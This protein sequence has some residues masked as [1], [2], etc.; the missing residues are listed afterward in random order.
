M[1]ATA[2]VSA[3]V[4][5]VFVG[6]CS[7]G[8]VRY[9]G[10]SPLGDPGAVEMRYSS[11]E[12]GFLD[13]GGSRLQAGLNFYTITS[14]AGAGTTFGTFCVE[15]SQ[16][17]GQGPA[18]YNLV[19]LPETPLPGAPMTQAQADEISA[20]LASARSLGWIG[21]RL[22]ADA[23][24][25]N[26]LGRI[27]AIQAA[28]WATLGGDVDVDSAQTSSSIRDA[29]TELMSSFDG[30]LRYAGL[31]GLVNDRR[32]DVLYVVPLPTA[33]LAG[34]GVLAAAFGVRASRRR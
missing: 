17:I 24:Q 25:A 3:S 34:A 7:A 15:L 16:H 1:S 26:Y 30:S 9:E 5:S 21:N 6:V 8:T 14:G 33:A 22:D 19:S 28:I 11:I 20:V 23:G 12:G 31:L 32:Q 2:W 27:G 18:V 13:V 10:V 29:Y 4:F